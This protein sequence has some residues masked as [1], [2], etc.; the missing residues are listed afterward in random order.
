MAHPA[1]LVLGTNEGR[2]EQFLMNTLGPIELWA[3]ST[4]AEDVAIR[5]RLYQ[6][7][8]GNKARRILARA[9]PRGS[10]RQEL[11]RRITLRVERGEIEAAAQSVVID[12]MVEEMIRQSEDQPKLEAPRLDP[13]MASNMGQA[14]E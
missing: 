7:L 1:L 2:Y 14:A 8:G 4:S 12:E 5:S 9:Y 10:A 13:G 3:L 11:R 6:R